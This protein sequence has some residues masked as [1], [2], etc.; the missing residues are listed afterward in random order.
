MSE[1]R[2]ICVWQQ[3]PCNSVA[4]VPSVRALP[5]KAPE[6]APSASLYRSCSCSA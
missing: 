4:P 3:H 1:L 5:S 6:H 2:H